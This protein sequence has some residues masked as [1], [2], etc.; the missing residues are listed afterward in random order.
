MKFTGFELT[1]LAA[2]A[3]AQSN[4]QYLANQSDPGLLADPQRAGPTPELVH[5]FYDLWPT[6]IAVSRS[7]RM[8]CNYPRGLDPTNIA[9]TVA[10]IFPNNTERAYP[11]ATYQTPPE[12]LINNSTTPASSVGNPNYLTGVQSV[13]IDPADRLWIL[14]TGRTATPDGTMLN[15]SPGGVKLVGVDLTTNEIFKTIVF[16]TTAAPAVSYFNDVRFDLSPKLTSSGQGV[17]YITDSSAVGLNAIIVVDLGTGEAWRRLQRHHSVQGD[18]G[19]V[20]IIWGEPVWNNQTGMPTADAFNFGADGIALSADNTELFYSTTGGREL[21]SISTAVLRA[22]DRNAEI[23]ARAAVKYRGETGFKDGMETDSNGM[24]YAGDQ[25]DNSLSYFNPENN[26][27]YTLVRDPRFSW[28][29]TLSVGF[30]GY[31]YFTENQLWLSPQYWF[32]KERRVKPWSLWRVKL[33]N[34]GTKVTS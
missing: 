26:Q 2:L 14:D 9:Y 3:N 31:L 4:V 10:E 1:A 30:D 34:G 5:L 18:V 15:A 16:D 8:F 20:P 24:I 7:G 13:V 29:D 17:A 28:T 25:E 11:N 19:F 22:R 32:G 33:P 6:G 23:V 21:W 27:L 12:G